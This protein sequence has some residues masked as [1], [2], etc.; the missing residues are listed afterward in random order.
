MFNLTMLSVQGIR[1]NT[2]TIPGDNQA[3]VTRIAG[4]PQQAPIDLNFGWK[5]RFPF[6]EHTGRQCNAFDLHMM[7]A[8]IL[9]RKWTV[10]ILV[11]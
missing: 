9:Q 1:G 3:V 5:Q 11:S 2:Y 4:F 6:V 10:E 8:R 7:R